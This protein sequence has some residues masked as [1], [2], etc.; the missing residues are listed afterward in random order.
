MIENESLE[1]ALLYAAGKLS[2][3]R[4][5]DKQRGVVKG[6]LDRKG[7][8]TLQYVTY[9]SFLSIGLGDT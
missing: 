3:G 1:L 6:F 8:F 5:D 4:L 9:I 7:D 2:T